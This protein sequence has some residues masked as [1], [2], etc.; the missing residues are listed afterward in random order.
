MWFVFVFQQAGSEG[1]LCQAESLCSAGSSSTLA[2]SVIEVE[3]ERTEP[4]LT[5][6]LRSN[7]EEEV[8]YCYVTLRHLDYPLDILALIALTYTDNCLKTGLS[9][10]L[11]KGARIILLIPYC[12]QMHCFQWL[13]NEEEAEEEELT[14]LTP[15]PTLSITEEILE[16]INQSRARE[17]LSS[18]HTDATVRICSIL[19]GLQ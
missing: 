18:I 14:P 19:Y 5:P 4:R 16:F 6:Q 11:E 17:G 2:S 10:M 1:E 8:F 12:I 15:P 13:S 7:P 3:A 9:L